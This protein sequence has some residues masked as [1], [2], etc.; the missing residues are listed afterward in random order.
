MPVRTRVAPDAKQR[1]ER[2]GEGGDATDQMTC[3]WSLE[4]QLSP[5]TGWRN[6]TPMCTASQVD[7]KPV[8][9]FA[10]ESGVRTPNRAR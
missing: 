5:L 3:L 1:R 10:F 9:F 8:H 6:L 2:A 7:K 4:S